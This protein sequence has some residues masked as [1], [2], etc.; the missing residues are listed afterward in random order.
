MLKRTII[1]ASIAALSITGAA[2][3]ENATLTLRSGERIQGQLIDMGG[4]GFTIRVN[5]NE[6]QVPTGEVALI[7][8]A[9]STMS[10]SDWDR[11]NSGQH[12]IWLRNGETVTGQLYDIGGTSPLRI[13]VKANGN[14]RELASNEV[15][16]IAMARLSNTET[17]TTGAGGGGQR[18]TVS[19]QQR[20]TPTGITVREGETLRINAEGEIRV[21]PDT[22]DRATPHGV[23]SQRMDPRAPMPRTFVGALIG[24]I[25]NGE[26]FGIGANGNIRAPG[27][28]QLFLGINDSNV[29]DND[30][31]FQ[32]SVERSGAPVRRR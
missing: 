32:V 17:G 3:Q 20:W 5:G 28:G 30:G 12:V 22:N 21:S 14:E 18:I 25:G 27:S 24:R 11:V 29:S 23:T 1:A 19:A 26:P 13:T 16:R 15:S 2:A 4:S 31:S 10:Q 6:R 9:G 8:F 7:D